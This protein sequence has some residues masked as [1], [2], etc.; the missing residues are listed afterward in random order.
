MANESS[1]LADGFDKLLLDMVK[2]GRPLVTPDG[3]PLKDE[4]TGQ[5]VMQP[6]TAADMNVIRSRLKDCGSTRLLGTGSPLDEIEDELDN[7]PSEEDVKNFQLGI[8]GM[9]LEEVSHEKDAATA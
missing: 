6:L 5:L 9:G 2:N 7:D 1:E 8:A 3:M 4:N